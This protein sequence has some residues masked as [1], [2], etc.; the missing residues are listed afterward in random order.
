MDACVVEVMLHVSHGTY[1][2]HGPNVFSVWIRNAM[3]S[4]L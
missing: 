4:R 3:L 1:S 2:V